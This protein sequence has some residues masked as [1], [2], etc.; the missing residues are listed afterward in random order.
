MFCKKLLIVLIIDNFPLPFAGCCPDDAHYVAVT[1]LIDSHESSLKRNAIIASLV[2]CFTS[3]L[4]FIFSDKAQRSQ[5]LSTSVT[6][7]KVRVDSKTANRY[8]Y[9]R[10]RRFI[11]D[12]ELN[13]YVAGNWDV[14]EGVKIGEWL[15]SSYLHQGLSMDEVIKRRGVVGPN[16]L[17]LKKPTI[18]SS[19]IREFSKPFYLY[20][21]FLIWTWGKIMY[22]PFDILYLFFLPRHANRFVP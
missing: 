16:E 1:A 11:Y 10:F 22:E 19:T 13:K 3:V 21:N 15:D 12:A 14:E 17:D 8:F 7:C 20:Q 4:S 6:Y 2:G 5:G 9:F 18:V